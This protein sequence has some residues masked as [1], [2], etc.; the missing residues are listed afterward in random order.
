LEVVLVFIVESV[1]ELQVYVVTVDYITANG[2][3]SGERN[4]Q[5]RT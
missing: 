1:I 5:E 4:E 2:G 3:N